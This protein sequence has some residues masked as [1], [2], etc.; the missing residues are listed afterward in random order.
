MGRTVVV[1]AKG[2]KAKS[3]KGVAPIMPSDPLAAEA[4]A[5]TQIAKE[6]LEHPYFS[7]QPPPKDHALM[8]T[9][10]STH[11]GKPKEKARSVTQEEE[12][13]RLLFQMRDR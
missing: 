4:H 11:E 9:F 7:E 6:A 5:L 2:P 1:E 3:R 8:P 13:Q 10:P 12:E